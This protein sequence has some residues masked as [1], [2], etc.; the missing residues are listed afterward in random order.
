MLFQSIYKYLYIT[1]IILSCLVFSIRITLSFLSKTF[2]I[3]FSLI[4]FNSISILFPI[5]LDMY[6]CIFS[7]IVLFI[8]ANVLLF[9][10]NYM[11]NDLFPKRFALLIILFVSSINCLIY[12]PNLIFVLI[13]WDGLG[14]V[15]FIL[16]IYY[17][18]HKALA[19]G[20]ITALTNRIGDV[21]ILLCIGIILNIAQWCPLSSNLNL[22]TI[23]TLLIIAAI[24]KRAQIPFSRWL[25]AAIAAPTP[26][27]ALVHSSTLVT[28]GVFLLFRFYPTYQ[29]S[30]FTLQFL[31]II[32]TLTILIA[33]I[34]AYNEIDIKKIVAMST[35]SQLGIIIACIGI[36]MPF[37]G[38][39]H[40]C[41]HA[42]FK[43]LLF[44][45][46]GNLI[47]QFS[48]A[49]DIR[50]FGNLNL[51]LPFT[52][53]SLNTANLALM[54]TPFLRGFYSKDIILEFILFNNFNMLLTIL[55]FLSIIITI[56]YSIRLFF[57][58]FCS[59]SN[60][61]PFIS[62]K[63]KINDIN[64]PLINIRISV[65]FIGN[66]LNWIIIAPQT[67][68]FFPQSIKLITLN[69]FI[70]RLIL[71][72]IVLL[73][74]ITKTQKLFFPINFNALIWFITPLSSQFVLKSSKKI[75]QLILQIVDNSWNELN[76]GQG[77]NQILSTN[78]NNLS[79]WNINIITSQFFL[80][81]II[82]ILII[83]S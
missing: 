10:N 20:M 28:A 17:Q 78:A 80:F 81:I 39:F 40:I 33:G 75:P 5:I 49:Q 24:T 4:Q 56:I 7:S 58:S 23:S 38:F 82:I 42:L 2:I 52:R 35:L 13:G 27:S 54:G 70:L 18:T 31:L 68:F 51:F 30:P 71:S 36:I 60:S 72:F 69:I 37:L 44:I 67:E 63:N 65:I 21:I 41:T 12:I 8:S 14:L 59:N 79:H 16:V 29:N 3:N 83:L 11:S 32:A 64:T 50:Q 26:V 57:L 1:L 46:V 62:F 66:L 55:I 6:N 34:A 77:L 43:A 9:A 53:A 74:N 15:S 22:F 61:W 19:A 48:H 47:K 25:P 45:C 73:I 76:T